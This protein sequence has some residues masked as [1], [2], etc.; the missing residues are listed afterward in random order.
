VSDDFSVDIGPD[1]LVQL[2]GCLCYFV[3][4]V[5]AS[6]VYY[7]DFGVV[8]VANC[9]SEEAC[10]AFGYGFFFV[11]GWYNKGDGGVIVAFFID[12]SSF[13]DPRGD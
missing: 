8:G 4:A 10:D 7:Y 3:C 2:D 5:G 11:V 9:A 12:L 6:V 13:P 1:F